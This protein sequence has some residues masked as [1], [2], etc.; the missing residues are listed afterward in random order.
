[1]PEIIVKVI[2]PSEQNPLEQSWKNFNCRL[3]SQT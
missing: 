3:E 2:D 1:M